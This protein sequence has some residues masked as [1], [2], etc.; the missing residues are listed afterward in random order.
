MPKLTP[1]EHALRKNA[2]R[3]V[4]VDS[5][6]KPVDDA[7]KSVAVQ[8]KRDSCD[9][10]RIV[11][12]VID[13]QGNVNLSAMPGLVREG[14]Y[15]DFTSAVDFQECHNRVIRM[16]DAFMTLDPMTRLKFNNDPAQMI[17]YLESIKGDFKKEDEAVAL[18][19]LPKPVFKRVKEETPE[20]D[21]WVVTRNGHE[22]SRDIIKT[23]VPVTPGT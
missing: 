14:R 1:E 11:K 18:G 20:G 17:T 6:N 2:T 23:A 16:N 8:D 15:G 5:N 13:S 4:Y 12:K 7:S 21:F 10:N 19:L 22:I 3:Q 9:I